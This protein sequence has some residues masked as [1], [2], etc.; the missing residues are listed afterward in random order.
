MPKKVHGITMK[1]TD[2]EKDKNLVSFE[3]LEKVEW[4]KPTVSIVYGNRDYVLRIKKKTKQ[5]IEVKVSK[6]KTG[7]K[8]R[9]T[10]S[11]IRKK[12]GSSY[13]TLSGTFIAS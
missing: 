13:V 1:E 6:L 9:W 7:R 2:Y 12:G 11:G 8:Y 3:F 4:K 5:E 10:I